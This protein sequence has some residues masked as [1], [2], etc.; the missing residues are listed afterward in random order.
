MRAVDVAVSAVRTMD[1]MQIVALV[2]VS[3]V[4]IAAVVLV[5]FSLVA[6]AAKRE[7]HAWRQTRGQGAPD[8]LAGLVERE[9]VPAPGGRVPQ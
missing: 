5:G 9:G 6:T 4:V 7:E 1:V 3:W 2:A 8:N